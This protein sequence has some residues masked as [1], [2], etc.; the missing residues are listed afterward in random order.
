MYNLTRITGTLHKDQYIFFIIS[1]SVLLR[2][3]NVSD[4]V[5][6]K[7]KTHIKIHGYTVHQQYPTLYF[8]TD[9]HNVKKRRIIKTF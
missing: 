9:A 8:P 3:R 5:V 4:K 2:M 6:G 1:R 7:I